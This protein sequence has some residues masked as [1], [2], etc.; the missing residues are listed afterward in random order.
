[1]MKTIIM[2]S[3]I[4]AAITATAFSIELQAKQVN[5]FTGIS[6]VISSES[7]FASNRNNHQGFITH[8]LNQFKAFFGRKAQR[9]TKNVLQ[10]RFTKKNY[11]QTKALYDCILITY[12]VDDVLVDGFYLS[13]KGVTKKQPLLIYNRG[14]NGQFGRSPII[15]ILGKKDIIDAGFVV[16]GSQYRENDEFGG[17]DLNDVLALV[18]IGKQL[19]TVK[20]KSVSM[21]GASRG[22]M[23]TY[24]AARKLPELKSLVILAGATDLARGLTIR[25][26]MARVHQ[27]RIPNYETNKEALLKERS[28]MHWAEELNPKTPILLLHGAKDIAVNVSHA[29]E[30]AKKLKGLNH[31]HELV[32]YPNGEHS[33][34]KNKAAVDEK[35]IT[36]LKIN[37]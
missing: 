8:S 27:A 4:I 7:C 2:N 25:P 18:E 5:P 26:E 19:P 29:Q 30:I 37:S 28:V 35:V 12:K 33:L 23:M 34:R 31:P 11:E 32:I 6:N 21:M 15:A 10:N 1:M 36:W 24:M 17:S 14:G 13:K 9:L 3:L 22:G 16:M 20:S